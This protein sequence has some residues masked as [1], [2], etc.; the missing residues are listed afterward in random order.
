MACPYSNAGYEKCY[1]THLTPE[2]QEKAYYYCG[3]GGQYR[4]CHIYPELVS[5]NIASL[6]KKVFLGNGPVLLPEAQLN[7]FLFFYREFHSKMRVFIPFL[8]DGIAKNEKCFYFP[9]KDYPSQIR[10]YLNDAGIAPE[11]VAILSSVEWYLTDGKF[12]GEASQKKYET[13]VQQALQEGYTGL[14][15]IGDGATFLRDI[16]GEERESFLAYEQEMHHLLGRMAMNAVCAYDLNGMP[17]K[18][19]HRLMDAHHIFAAPLTDRQLLYLSHFIPSL[20]VDEISYH[21]GELKETKLKVIRRERV[22]YLFCDAPADRLAEKTNF[23]SSSN[24]NNYLESVVDRAA[25]LL[26]HHPTIF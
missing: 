14:R 19:F 5:K 12:D 21:V 4:S 7:H 17:A 8:L 10:I 25:D 2:T 24:V 13:A 9:M 1:V 22:G 26:I 3:G 11:K 23:S 15:V 20:E 18:S 16:E 6:E